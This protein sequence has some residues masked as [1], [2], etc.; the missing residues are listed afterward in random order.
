[1]V[2]QVLTRSV[3]RE[4][5]KIFHFSL[6]GSLPL[7]HALVLNTT[8]GTLL[9]L[10]VSD[11]FMP[12]LVRQEQFTQTEMSVLLPLLEF[13]PYHCP[14]E[15]LYAS[16]YKDGKVSEA[17]IADARRYLDEVEEGGAWDREI[18]PVRCALSRARLKIRS[19]GVDISSILSTGYVL[20]VIQDKSLKRG[21]VL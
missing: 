8:F 6:Q 11:P 20:V 9:Y 5:E 1:M 18:R 16:F 3:D 12:R 2:P 14:Y 13:F 7:G 19:F 10:E 15:I 17:D 4:E 21:I